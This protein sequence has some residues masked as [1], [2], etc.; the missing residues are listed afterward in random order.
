MPRKAFAT[1][2]LGRRVLEH[3]R[4]LGGAA[5]S[6]IGTLN[7]S[8]FFTSVVLLIDTIDIVSIS[9]LSLHDIVSLVSILGTTSIDT[10]SIDT[11]LNNTDASNRFFV[12]ES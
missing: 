7:Y 8:T 11:K 1:R 10:T 9:L 2:T 5:P 6:H 3:E 12:V 4:L